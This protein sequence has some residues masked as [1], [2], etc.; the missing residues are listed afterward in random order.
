M[1]TNDT[2]E[3][4]GPEPGLVLTLEAQ[5]YLRET[6]KWATFLGIVGFVL[7]AFILLG[8]LFVGTIMSLMTRLQPAAMPYPAAVG[9]LLS[10]VYILVAVFYFFFSLYLFQ[11][12]SRIK[13]GILFN[14][15]IEVGSALGK[16]K[17]FFKMWGITTIVILA[18]Y[19]LMIIIFIIVGVGASMMHR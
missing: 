3:Q 14:N 15:P 4:T 9:G 8:A 12:G 5:G 6:G 11:F 13:K 17:S 19:A 2:F 16:L 18:L 7:T 10:F 1:E